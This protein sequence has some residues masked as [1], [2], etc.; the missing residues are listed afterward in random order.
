MNRIPRI[1]REPRMVVYFTVHRENNGAV[2]AERAG[3]PKG[4]HNRK[5][6]MG[7]HGMV[8]GINARPVRSA[9]AGFRHGEHLLT[10]GFRG[11]LY[12]K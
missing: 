8:A 11:C 9:V 6:F 2:A 4:I 12:F 10:E 5:A 1:V 7:E 3:F